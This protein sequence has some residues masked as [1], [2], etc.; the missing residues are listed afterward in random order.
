MSGIRKAFLIPNLPQLAFEHSGQGNWE[1]LRIA[2]RQAAQYAHLAQPDVLVIYS[3]QWLS[4]LGHSFQ[5][6]TSPSGLHVDETWHELGELPYHF[7][8][9]QELT[10]LTET[11]ARE[12]GLATKLVDYEGFPVDTGT[13]VA[14]KYFNPDQS[15]PVMLLSANIY[16]SR[17]DVSQLGQAVGEAIEQAG[18][19][20]ILI[21]SSLLSDRLIQD[22]DITPETDRFSDPESD[23]L[24]QQ[25]L[26]LIKQGN[27]QKALAFAPEYAANTSVEMGFRGFD[28]MMG[29]MN[30]PNTPA[31]L[32][33]YE[34][35]LG[36]GAAVVAYHNN[37]NQ[38]TD[39]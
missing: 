35:L 21:N 18:R 4:V 19:K 3:A 38:S 23:R 27:T 24:N 14:L 12:R 36:A 11:H 32:L 10:K 37:S 8:T 30:W 5:Y 13:L 6:A 1:T 2:L 31:E 15:I 33:A 28:W 34:P 29:A 16:A 9:D 22:E 7:H 20:A 25:M 26:T 17:K 39:P